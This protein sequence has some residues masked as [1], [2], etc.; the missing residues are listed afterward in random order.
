MC[1]EII[2]F[3]SLEKIFRLGLYEAFPLRSLLS[4]VIYNCRTDLSFAFL[5][6]VQ[7]RDKGTKICW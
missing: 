1:F 3:F 2:F 7:L 5:T 6:T 4:S